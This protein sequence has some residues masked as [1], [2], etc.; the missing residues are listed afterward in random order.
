MRRDLV[1]LPHV[2]KKPFLTADEG[3]TGEY[4]PEQ[5]VVPAGKIR[6]QY[7]HHRKVAIIF[8]QTL[9]ECS[10]PSTGTI[11]DQVCAKIVKRSYSRFCGHKLYP[12]ITVL[13]TF[14]PLSFFRPIKILET[15]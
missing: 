8:F 10:L 15:F 1:N 2:M 6:A 9:P 5:E 14:S 13:C 7:K 11:S 12:R 4:W 3:W